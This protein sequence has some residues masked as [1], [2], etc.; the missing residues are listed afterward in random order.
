MHGLLSCRGCYLQSVTSAHH[1]QPAP[2]TLHNSRQTPPTCTCQHI[3]THAHA[4]TFPQVHVPTWPFTWL[5]IHM[6]HH[7][8]IH[9]LLHDSRYPHIRCTYPHAHKGTPSHWI[10]HMLSHLSGAH[11][12][13]QTCINTFMHMYIQNYVFT[14]VHRTYTENYTRV[15]T[16]TL[17]QVYIYI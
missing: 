1:A 10:P 12:E 5:R 3:C 4:Q 6:Q 15:H 13:A 17:T 8:Q 9:E 14:Q 11:T 7:P 2:E 16:T